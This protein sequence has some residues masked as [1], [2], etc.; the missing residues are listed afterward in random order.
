MEQAKARAQQVVKDE[1]ARRHRE[2]AAACGN[3]PSLDPF[4]IWK[5]VTGPEEAGNC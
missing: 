3:G 2:E 4:E 5:G 1:L